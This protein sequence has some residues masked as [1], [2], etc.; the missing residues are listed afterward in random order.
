M[1]RSDLRLPPTPP[2]HL[3]LRFQTARDH[4]GRGG[5]RWGPAADRLDRI[6]PGAGWGLPP[7]YVRSCTG[8]QKGS[9]FLACIGLFP[10]TTS[11]QPSYSIEKLP[12]HSH[13]QL[14]YAM[15]IRQVIDPT[16]TFQLPGPSLLVCNRTARVF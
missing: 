11:T 3:L 10:K 13:P 12:S 1:V 5:Y 2:H 15:P 7:L 6:E 8:S 4:L 16:T 14:F 9:R